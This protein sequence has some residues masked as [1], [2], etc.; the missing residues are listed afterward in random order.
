MNVAPESGA[1][2]WSRTSM[3]FVISG[4]TTMRRSS[5]NS[6]ISPTS[7]S[8]RSRC[9]RHVRSG[10]RPMPSGCRRSGRFRRVGHRAHAR[11][12]DRGRLDDAFGQPARIPALMG[13]HS[14]GRPRPWPRHVRLRQC[15]LSPHQR[16]RRQGRRAGGFED[17]SRP[18]LFRRLQQGAPGILADLRF[19]TRLHR[20]PQ[21]F[22]AS[23]CRRI[24][25]RIS[26]MGDPMEQFRRVA[27]RCCRSS[28]SDGATGSR[29]ETAILTGHGE[30]QR[31]RCHRR[32]TERPDRVPG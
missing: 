28:I 16:E 20:A 5:A 25:F 26:T 18:L 31:S 19:A 24:T 17:V 32:G 12:Q 3:C 22:K 4:P 9:S 11:R 29:R 8:S 21:Q 10:W 15:S 13:F 2:A 30:R 27:E 6:R 7:R 14:A 23:G 1:S